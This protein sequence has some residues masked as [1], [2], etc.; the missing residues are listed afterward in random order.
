MQINF[1]F[2]CKCYLKVRP[3]KKGRRSDSSSLGRTVLCIAGR[4][5]PHSMLTEPALPEGRALWGMASCLMYSTVPSGKAPALGRKPH[6]AQLL[7]SSPSSLNHPCS[8]RVAGRV[9][10][11]NCFALVTASGWAGP[12]LLLAGLLWCGG[13]APLWLRAAASVVADAGSAVRAPAVAACG[14]CPDQGLACVPPDLLWQAD[15]WPP[16]HQGSRLCPSTCTRPS[17]WGVSLP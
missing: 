8:W 13:Q 17:V 4:L 15:S 3:K 10:P 7:P 6:V 1:R 11:L 5:R 16:D 12:S 2:T 9:T 14:I